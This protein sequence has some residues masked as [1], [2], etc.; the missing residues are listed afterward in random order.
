MRQSSWHESFEGL[1]VVVTGH[2]G[3]KGAWLCAWL[4]RLGANV[5]GFSLPELPTSPS[6]FEVAAV[7]STLRDVRG[8]VTDPSAVARL[9][10]ESRPAVVF[11]L[12]AQ[13]LVTEAIRAPRETFATNALGTVNVL[14]AVRRSSSV[15]AAVFVTT[16]KVY[17]GAGPSHH[18]SETDALGGTE[19]YTASKVMAE[20]AVTSYR[21]TYLAADAPKHP[22]VITVRSGNV[23]GGGDFAATRLIPDCF[24]A[25]SASRAV[26]LRAPEHIRPWQ[27]VLEPLRGYLQLAAAMLQRPRELSPCYNFA[28]DRC[29][30][31]PVRTVVEHLIALSERGA[32]HPSAT[33]PLPEEAPVLLLDASRASRD[34]GW[35]PVFRLDDAL[36]E[37]VAWESAYRRGDDMGAVTTEQIDRYAA[38]T[39]AASRS[40]AR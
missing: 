29:D 15:R 30:G 13:S 3:F 33:G 9:F 12:A 26:E 35:Q 31:V 6:M 32:W 14:E 4:A 21:Q 37:T 19:P 5:T 39:D 17:A 11:H 25:F 18:H 22:S 34:L 16:D 38:R 7:G 28:P 24:A 2:T 10:A 20:L 1:P 23:I 40:S 8:S 36:R 27:F